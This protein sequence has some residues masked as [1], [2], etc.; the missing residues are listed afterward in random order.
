MD[1]EVVHKI[2][3]YVEVTKDSSSFWSLDLFKAIFTPF[4]GTLTALGVFYLTSRRDR[5]K[6]EA[7][8]AN[9]SRNRAK[10]ISN[11]L[12][13][14]IKTTQKQTMSLYEFLP[15]LQTD[16]TNY[17]P[18]PRIVNSNLDRLIRVLGDEISF[19][20]ITK[21]DI[22]DSIDEKIEVYNKLVSKVDFVDAI[23]TNLMSVAQ[24]KTRQKAIDDL[25][26]QTATDGILVHSNTIMLE[27]QN[28]ESPT[29][30]EQ[31]FVKGFIEIDKA[32]RSQTEQGIS[33][34]HNYL[35][36]PANA[37]INRFYSNNF[38]KIE[39]LQLLARAIDQSRRLYSQMKVNNDIY[40]SMI[41]EAIVD[42]QPQLLVLRELHELISKAISDDTSQ[43]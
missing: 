14:T 33:T 2:L 29:D 41:E 22:G 37:F 27:L 26:I 40:V 38:R 4:V 30:L 21:V 6:E 11:L 1:N 31:E 28:S 17:H 24:N 16:F 8:K 5:R 43:S 39:Q 35:V 3:C 15:K 34:F 18:I 7:K 23:L 12:N 25:E 19:T 32:L 9:D 10:Y 36:L 42:L 20:S 13:D